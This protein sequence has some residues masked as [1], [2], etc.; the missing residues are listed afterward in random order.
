MHQQRQCA[1]QDRADV[2]SWQRMSGKRLRAPQLFV[3]LARQRH[4]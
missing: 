1:I 2:S 4:L 3:R